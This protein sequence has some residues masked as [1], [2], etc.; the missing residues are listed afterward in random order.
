MKKRA[1]ALIASAAMGTVQAQV[2]NPDAPRAY[3]GGGI[4]LTDHDFE[5]PGAANIDSDG[6]QASG[7]IFGGYEFDRTWGVEAGFIRYSDSH[8]DYTRNGVRGR[9][10]STGDSFYIAGKATAQIDPRFSVYGKLGI[11]R[12]EHDLRS[13]DRFYIRDENETEPYAA[14]GV[15]YTV[16]RQWA[17]VAEYE[18]YG[19]Q[20]DFGAKA[21]VLS[22]GARFSF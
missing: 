13:R 15:Q 18:R 9:A 20:K 4:G 3:I 16:D 19:S 8:A 1:V 12:N 5:L 6:W 2:Q 21:D 10:E 22:I 11:S 7:K 17:V 14:I